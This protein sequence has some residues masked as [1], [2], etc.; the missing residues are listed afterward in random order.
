MLSVA[1]VLRYTSLFTAVHE[2][3]QSGRLG[4]IVTVEHRE[5][6]AYW[7]MAHSYVRGNW[8][9]S[10]DTA[11]MI[12]TKCCHDLD[13]LSWILSP[14]PVRRLHSFGS[15]MH[16]RAENA[17][18]GA[19]DR[20]IHGCPVADSCPF[21]APRMY[22]SDSVEWP[23]T[24]LSTDLSVQGR[25]HALE[26]GPY[27]RCVYRCDNDVVDHQVVTMEHENGTL[28]TLIMQ[29]HSHEE[30]RTMRYDG[31]RATLRARFGYTQS[32]EITLHDHSTG[33]AETVPLCGTHSG[34]HG[35]G[36]T[37][38][39]RAF[40]EAI[41]G[42]RSTGRTSAQASLESHLLAFAAERSRENG[43][44]VDMDA[45]RRDIRPAAR[46]QP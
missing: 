6:V 11:P 16:F 34:G 21:Y 28:A 3:V 46:D 45:Y 20:C 41:R 18:P 31:T 24:A 40:A 27:G 23:V 42:G 22:P 26:T 8:R 29:G 25:T 2:I 7:H 37:G 1:H 15:L 10:E 13:V 36:D 4:D 39:I 30:G 19:P 35:G 14:F 5:N 32:P 44:V 9:R 33:T 12:L 17:P 43:T 38:T